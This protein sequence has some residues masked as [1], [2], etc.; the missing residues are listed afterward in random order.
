M[1]TDTSG[2]VDTVGGVKA[3]AIYFP[4]PSVDWTGGLCSRFH[5]RLAQHRSASFAQTDTPH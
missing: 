1:L 5:V 2:G 4:S 3:S